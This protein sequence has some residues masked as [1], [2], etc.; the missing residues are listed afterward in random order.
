MAV[1]VVDTCESTQDLAL[2]AGRDEAPGGTVFAAREQTAG[3]G[4]RGNLWESPAG[5]LYFSEILRPAVPMAMLQG[6]GALATLAVHDAL[7]GLG[8]PGLE[9][10][11][12]NDVVCGG[13]KLAGVLA[14]AAT[15]ENGM[16]VAV[17]IGVNIAPVK[18]AHL[19]QALLATSVDEV[20]AAAGVSDGL[21]GKGDA[22]KFDAIL[23]AIKNAL[24][25]RCYDWVEKLHQG[26][27]AA[28][29]L[30]PF[31]HDYF[32]RLWLMGESVVV[33]SH[34]GGFVM[35]GRFA[36]LDGW[37]RACVVD[38]AGAEHDFAPEQ[39]M[40]RPLP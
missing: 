29:P 22:E 27:G 9:I 28:G 19:D 35:D 5:G 38:E 20:L 31:L 13:K 16:F 4:R 39:V 21:A 34:E 12:P 40:L 25:N 10:K 33:V 32:D 37:G 14:Q 26:Q 30:G 24:E 17:G 11:W 1:T 2:A 3:H 18:P 6:V 36:G 15:S 8:V 23:A 7:S